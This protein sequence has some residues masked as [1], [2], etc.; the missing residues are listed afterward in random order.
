MPLPKER[1]YVP[2]TRGRVIDA[3]GLARISHTIR[4]TPLSDRSRSKSASE[5]PRHNRS[6]D[7]SGGTIGLSSAKFLRLQNLSWEDQ[8]LNRS[9][10]A[11]LTFAAALSLPSAGAQAF[12]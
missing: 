7:W 2:R 12:D 5:C 11:A 8:M 6:Q 1:L 4:G 3:A 10:I 9:A